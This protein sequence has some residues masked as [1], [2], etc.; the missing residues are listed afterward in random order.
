MKK[1]RLIIV[2]DELIIAHEIQMSLTRLGYEVPSIAM[3]GE[4]ALEQVREIEPDLVLMDIKLKGSMSGIEAAALIHERHHIP[5]IYVTANADEATVSRARTTEPYGFIYKPIQYDVLRAVIETA[6]YKHKMELTLIEREAW[7]NAALTSIGD[8][9]IATNTAGSVTFMN[10][11]AERITEWTLKEAEGRPLEEIVT[12]ISGTG[13]KPL[14]GPVAAVIRDGVNRGM[15]PDTVLVSR[16]GRRIPIA[17]SAA[18]IRD[19]LGRMIG[20]IVVFRDI[21]EHRESEVELLEGS[22]RL[23]S[24]LDAAPAGYFLLDME[25]RI[26]RVNRVWLDMFDH[27]R[28]EDVRGKHF[29]EVMQFEDTEEGETFFREILAGR[30]ERRTGEFSRRYA[31]GR[32]GFHSLSIS[33]VRHQGELIGVE[34]FAADDT[35]RRSAGQALARCEKQLT[36]LF[37]HAPDACWFHDRSGTV[38][39]ANS[40]AAAL[41]GCTV[42]DLSGKAVTGLLRF[43]GPDTADACLHPAEADGITGPVET[44]VIRPDGEE[45]PVELSTCAVVRDGTEAVYCIARDIRRRKKSEEALIE[46][47]ELFSR[48]IAT[49]PD[50]I[51]RTTIEGEI[52]FVSEYGL[53]ISGYSARDLVGKNMFTFIVPEDRERARDTTVRMFEGRLGPR[54]YR[55]IL[56]NGASLPFEVNGDL[57]RDEEGRPF[58]MVYI[59]RDVS[60]RKQSLAA[61]QAS[62]KKYRDLFENSQEAFLIL[63]DGRF[64]DCNQATVDMLGLSSKDQVINARP[65]DLSPVKQSDGRKSKEKA[66]EMIQI[67]LEKGSHRFEWDHQRPNGDIFPVE[68]LL[69]RITKE[70]GSKIIHTA[71]RDITEQKKVKQLIERELQEKKVLLR[72]IHHRVKNNLNVIISL[73]GLQSRRITSREDAVDAFQESCD[74]IFSMALVHEYLYKSENFSQIDIKP[75]IESISEQLSRT[76]PMGRNIRFTSRIDNIYLNVTTAVPCGLIL[77]ELITN[78]YKYAFEGRVQGALDVSFSRDRDTVCVLTVRDDGVGLPESIDIDSVQTL[79]LRLVKILTGQLSGDLTISRKEGTTFTIRFKADQE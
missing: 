5:V 65:S 17:D 16:S 2:E 28:E 25:G 57:L 34:G 67:A 20:V 72:E 1:P 23:A 50:M 68:V 78:A 24:L 79:G 30:E 77:N 56:K 29:L 31:D 69:T 8:A 36:R 64:T 44:V 49:V 10:P 62:E 46:A 54:E 41:F 48:L 47:Q 7:L 12:L 63:E 37:D 19:A 71:W 15:S 3:S 74:R 18:P 52:E 6:L 66:I 14:A 51:I 4:E 58:G 32:E 61:L 42:K 53:D 11:V 40:R 76:H 70:D 38:I 22:E 35:D 39:D 43:S 55:L 73:L 13:G 21:S 59:C 60:E 9:V 27:S 45:I 26:K 75:Y 33:P